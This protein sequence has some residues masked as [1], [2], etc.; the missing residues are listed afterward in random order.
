MITSNNT[1]NT[2]KQMTF[3]PDP[4]G[5]LTKIMNT[6][7]GHGLNPPERMAP[8]V[9]TLLQYKRATHFDNKGFLYSEI[10]EESLENQHSNSMTCALANSGLSPLSPV[11]GN[12]NNNGGQLDNNKDSLLLQINSN[13]LDHEANNQQTNIQ[14]SQNAKTPVII[15]RHVCDD[16]I[17]EAQR[18]ND[19]KHK[20]SKAGNNDHHDHHANEPSNTG[21]TLNVS[22]A[23]NVVPVLEG[24]LA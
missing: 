24:S 18:L 7:D 15:F 17:N 21:T 8:I 20:K 19:K 14:P 23:I 16:V 10:S 2:T 3:R 1:S 22:T 13:N 4:K 6:T 9:R 5:Y 12:I 11:A